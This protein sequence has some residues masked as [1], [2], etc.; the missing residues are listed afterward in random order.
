[1]S[2]TAYIREHVND[3]RFTVAR[4]PLPDEGSS[5]PKVGQPSRFGITRLGSRC[6]GA[7]TCTHPT[8]GA[9]I[10]EVSPQVLAGGRHAS[11]GP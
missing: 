6:T 4:I 9:A 3:Q 7:R 2:A 5:I 1:M 11:S 8:L 10:E